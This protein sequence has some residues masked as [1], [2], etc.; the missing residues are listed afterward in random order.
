[1][2]T[3][4][5]RHT[6]TVVSACMTAEGLPKFVLTEVQVTHEEYDNGGHFYEVEQRLLADGLEEPFVHFAEAEA[7]EF[8]IVG[9]KET[10]AAAWQVP[11]LIIEPKEQED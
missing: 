11:D 3:W 10:L 1:M 2:T 9:L 8:L 6:I 5:G 4:Q 7:P